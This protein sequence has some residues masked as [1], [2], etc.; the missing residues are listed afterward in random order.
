M[1]FRQCILL[2]NIRLR[3]NAKTKEISS[4]SNLADV[5]TFAACA[6]HLH[7][8]HGYTI[9]VFILGEVMGSLNA[10]SIHLVQITP[11]VLG[12]DIY[13]KMIVLFRPRENN[14]KEEQTRKRISN[15]YTENLKS[16]DQFRRQNWAQ[17]MTQPLFSRN[18]S[19]LSPQHLCFGRFVRVYEVTINKNET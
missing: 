19:T 4:C 5:K 7:V 10:S 3:A 17:Q 6:T 14:R 8:I 2:P 11:D 15:N 13:M 16:F 18:L 12:V 9:P 1:S